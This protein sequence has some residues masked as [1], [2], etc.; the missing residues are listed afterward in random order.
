MEKE[1]TEKTHVSLSARLTFSNYEKIKQLSQDEKRSLNF[2]FNKITEG[3]N[4][5]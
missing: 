1:K 4:N 5:G 2:I 3:Y